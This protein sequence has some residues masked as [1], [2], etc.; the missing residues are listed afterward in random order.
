MRNFSN[1]D[2]NDRGFKNFGGRD[3][4][5]DRGGFGGN[6]GGFGGSRGGDRQMFSAVCD[7]CGN[8]CQVPF[9]PSGEKPVYCSN[10][11]EKSD[12][13]DGGRRFESRDNN[14][15][16]TRDYRQENAN[17]AQMEAINRKLDRI[18]DLL[19]VKEQKELKEA[20]RPKKTKKVEEILDLE[21]KEI[22]IPSEI[23]VPVEKTQE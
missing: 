1:N 20:K 13:R 2:R 14:R 22:E 16:D 7:K 21:V 18:L 4:G 17:N 11:F 3:S 19:T 12:S 6:R 23:E 15:G 5:G 9:R 8:D 10:C